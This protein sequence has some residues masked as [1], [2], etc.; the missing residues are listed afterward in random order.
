[1]FV[2]VIPRMLAPRNVRCVLSGAVKNSLAL[3]K[4]SFV[5]M[6]IPV[7]DVVV[8]RM[9]TFLW[10]RLILEPAPHACSSHVALE[11]VHRKPIEQ[12]I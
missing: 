1:M 5:A 10:G 7:I 2:A 12:D 11:S 9:L 6:P 4:A 3:A 8:A